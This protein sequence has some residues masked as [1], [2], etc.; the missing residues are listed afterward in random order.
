[1]PHAL[2]RAAALVASAGA[3]MLAACGGAASTSTASSDSACPNN[4]TVR[5]AVEPYADAA[6]LQPLYQQVATL[7]STKLGCT[8]K[9]TITNNYT[10]E[11]EAMRA[12]KLDVGEFGPLGYVFAHRVANAEPLV[13]FA[14]ASGT[15]LTYYASV[16]TT[17]NTG[18][19]DLKGVA[20]HTFAYS[21]PAST[22]GHLFPAYGLKKAGVD[23]DTGV[24]AQYAGSH[25]ASF[26]AIM[27]HKVDA[28]EL[29]S[30]TIAGATKQGQ[31]RASDYVT[32]WKSDPIPQDP[33]AVRGDLPAGFK[34][35][36][37]QAL[38]ALDLSSVSD[39]KGQLIAAKLVSQTNA[40]YQ[41]IADLANTL[42]IDV[43]HIG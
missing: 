32:L 14:D 1:M 6:Q 12:K 38:L 28:G 26:L 35:K 42:G 31:Y 36:L 4:G 22:S 29:N 30:D 34:T 11:V 41:Q 15:P 39:P 16:V 7:L 27:N 18:I 25:T 33:I 10:A 5:F 21:D 3:L 13:T 24:K 37:K 9:L 2:R 23:P 19:T 8:V 40:P 43:N 20:G 17:P